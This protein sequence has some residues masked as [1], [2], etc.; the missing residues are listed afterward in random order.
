[1][2]FPGTSSVSILKQNPGSCFFKCQN[3]LFYF[4]W[5]IHKMFVMVCKGLVL[6][7]KSKV[8]TPNI[9]IV[10]WILCV[11]AC[12]CVCVCVCVF[13]CVCEWVG[14]S[15]V[16][17]WVVGWVGGCVHLLNST[18]SLHSYFRMKQRTFLTGHFIL[19][20]NQRRAET[21]LNQC[22]SCFK[23]IRPLFTIIRYHFCTSLYCQPI[24]LWLQALTREIHSN[25][26]KLR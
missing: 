13:M 17:G 1:M 19:F 7:R 9:F 11:C 5:F 25:Y 23:N 14:G 3:A 4:D 8:D 22:A 15:G 24:Y 18:E 20:T 6:P 10:V 21:R 26:G 12:V 2:L 16:D